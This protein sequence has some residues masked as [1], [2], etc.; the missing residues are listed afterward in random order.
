MG[1]PLYILHNAHEYGPVETSMA[2]LHSAQKKNKRKNTL[3][4]YYIHYFYK[5]NV[6]T[7]EQNKGKKHY[8][9]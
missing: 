3:E 6:I 8:S 7:R 5:H 4:N 1:Y 2:L 9:K